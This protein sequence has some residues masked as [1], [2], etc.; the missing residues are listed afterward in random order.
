MTEEP[1]GKDGFLVKNL[2]TPMKYYP[3]VDE[4][5][6]LYE[7][8]RILQEY[9][10]GASERM[11]YAEIL[12][13][14]SH[15]ELIGRLT[16]RSILKGLDPNLDPDSSVFQGKASEFFNLGILWGDS[17]F[18]DCQSNFNK[19]VKEFMLPLP[20]PVKTTDPAWKPLS[21]MLTYNESVLPVL[22]HN[23]DAVIGVIRMEEIF[24]AIVRCYS[25][26]GSK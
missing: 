10:C 3:N 23:G 20:P 4:N 14:S 5:I 2:F 9:T 11:R 13:V 17:F 6:S 22:D 19:N 24:S 26:N 15:H 1:A 8:V 7:A 21:I 18:T 16:L 12:V 25:S